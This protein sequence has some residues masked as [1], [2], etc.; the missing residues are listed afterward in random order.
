MK[1]NIKSEYYWFGIF[2]ICFII[3]QYLS[4]E[5][6]P[7]YGGENPLIVYLLGI[8]PNLFPGIGIPALFILFIRTFTKP[9]NT[10]IWFGEYKF[11]TAVI[12][13]TAGLVLWEFIQLT[14]KL[15]F[16]WHDVLWTLIGAIIFLLIWSVTPRKFK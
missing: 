15:V 10:T 6:R 2:A 8:S 5:V 9:N 14:G 12:L 16:D 4:S 11:I 1:M 13:S 3:F 7:N